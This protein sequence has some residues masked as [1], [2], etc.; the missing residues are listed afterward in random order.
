MVRGFSTKDPQVAILKKLHAFWDSDGNPHRGSCSKMFLSRERGVTEGVFAAFTP[1]KVVVMTKV[2]LSA[3]S[4]REMS[5]MIRA[6]QVDIGFQL[7]L[8]LREHALELAVFL[9]F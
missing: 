5:D 9:I 8:P 4:P 7:C 3:E 6:M 1:A 2:L